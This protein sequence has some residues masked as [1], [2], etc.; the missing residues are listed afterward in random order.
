MNKRGRRREEGRRRRLREEDDLEGWNEKEQDREMEKKRV[1]KR[2]GCNG[3][4]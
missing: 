4:E 2:E 1:S 3:L